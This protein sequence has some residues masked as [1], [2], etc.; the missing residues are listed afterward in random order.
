LILV[1]SSII[2]TN[3]E[4]LVVEV[5][6]RL[7]VDETINSHGGALVVGS[8]SLLSE[9]GSPGS[10]QDGESR[11]GQHRANSR[12][13]KFEAEL[14]GQNS[15]DKT[16]LESSRDDV[17][18]HAREQEVDALGTSV[19][20]PR[21][22]SRL[23]RKVKVEIQLEQVLKN[24]G[25]NPANSLLRHTSKDSIAKFLE[26]SRANP[27]QTISENRRRSDRHGRT[28]NSSGSINVHGIDNRL[29]IERDLDIEDLQTNLSTRGSLYNSYIA[30]MSTTG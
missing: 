9:L 17:K 22:P 4:L 23:A 6:D 2:A 10:G 3:L 26:H 27:R 28:A 16:D 24:I 5:L 7:V 15:T 12:T 29:E 1:E 14:V 13:G 21:Q 19:D 20:S 30:N 18:H 11:V 25:R 8:I